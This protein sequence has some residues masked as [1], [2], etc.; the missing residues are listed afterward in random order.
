MKRQYSLQ[1]FPKLLSQMA[2][3]GFLISFTTNSLSHLIKTTRGKEKLLALFQYMAELFKLTAEDFISTRQIPASVHLLNAIS[4][5]KSMKN[6]RKLMRILMFTDDISTIEKIW[7]SNNKFKAFHY[8]RII[9]SLS[10][11]VYYIL[12]NLV[13]CADIGI[14]SKFISHA[15]IKWKDTKDL[16]SVARAIFGL[17]I[18]YLASDKTWKK[19]E[20]IQ[21]ALNEKLEKK[22][23]KG[24]RKLNDIENLIDARREYRFKV[25]D[26]VSMILRLV[27][28][29]HALGFPLVKNCSKI[30]VAICGLVTS[31]LSIFG[32][33]IGEQVARVVERPRFDDVE[34]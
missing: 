18:T 29:G 23:K 26:V 31:A 1:E 27:M 10:N 32:V 11:I 14:I 19:I 21:K 5:E 3:A 4:I 30:F 15:N 2:P 28:L 22:V 20:G 6:G 34:S 33:L 16:S 7:K 25:I 12:D 8:L 17:I 9:L 24:S 13:W